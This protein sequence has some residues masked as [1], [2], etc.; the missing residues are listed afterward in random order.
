MK[1]SKAKQSSHLSQIRTIM[2]KADGSMGSRQICKEL[3][4]QGIHLSRSYVLKLMQKGEALAS[5]RRID[6]ENRKDDI[7]AWLEELSKLARDFNFQVSSLI[8][9][10]PTDLDDEDINYLNVIT[11]GQKLISEIFG[12]KFGTFKKGAVADLVV[13]DYKEPTHMEKGNLLGHYLF[14]MQSSMVESV[15]VG[16]KWVMKNRKIPGIDETKV[17]AKS[18]QLAR[19]LWRKMAKSN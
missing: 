9:R 3:E 13:M 14:G 11:G 10:Y 6:I 8:R 2:A 5:Q 16:G 1:Y 18:R 15:M 7:Q 17:F 4:E 19:E 12:K